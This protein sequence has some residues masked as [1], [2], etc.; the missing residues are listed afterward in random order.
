[1]KN[2]TV[3]LLHRCEKVVL[4][5]P[6]SVLNNFLQHNLLTVGADPQSSLTLYL[7]TG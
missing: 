6:F 3:N 7:A 4:Q 5:K 1:M 2:I